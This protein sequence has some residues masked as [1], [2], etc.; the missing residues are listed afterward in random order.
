MNPPRRATG[1]RGLQAAHAED[2]GDLLGAVAA[3]RAQLAEGDDP[4]LRLRLGRV[5][6][7]LGEGVS[8]RQ[9]LSPLDRSTGEASINANRLLA[10]LDER[11]GALTSAQVRWERILAVDIDD[12]QAHAHLG[13]LRPERPAIPVDSALSTLVAPEGVTTARLRLLRELG[14]GSSATVYLVHDD[15]L[16]LPL[17]LKVLHPQLASAARAHARARFFAEA[18]LAARLRHP[19]V[20]AVYDIDEASRALT[21]E[22]V[23]GGTLRERLRANRGRP[24]V[25]TEVRPIA[26]SLLEALV[27]VHR[28][29]I[30][31]G[32][33]KPGNIL[34]RSDDQIVLADFGIASLV[35]L[36]VDR[37]ERPGGTPLYL[38][39]EQ[40][41]GAAPSPAADLFAAG[42]IIWELAAGRPMREAKDLAQ[43]ANTPAP[44]LPPQAQ[45]TLGP[46]LTALVSA[47]TSLDP[48]T[49]QSATTPLPD[50]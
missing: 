2:S 35:G 19:G 16:D 20:V 8:A 22:Y 32:D 25:A 12:P 17:A 24:P 23:A 6:L 40:F 43:A 29:G 49:R 15:R 34:M 45:A 4:G 1:D 7:A 36:D 14:R 39:P 46:T 28:A 18:R 30:T 11:E 37:D 41:R 31:H 3:L 13:R 33:V 47:L 10:E 5:L 42:A 44:P 50:F 27:Y 21:M 48:A 38:A 26:R 9:V